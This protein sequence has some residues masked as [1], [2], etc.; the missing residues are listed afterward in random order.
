MILRVAFQPRE[1]T[2]P[3]RKLCVVIDVLRAT[4]TLAT[5]LQAGC[6]DILLEPT[7][8]A[9]RASAGGRLLCGEEG[10]VRPEGFDFGNSPAEFART[11]L[12]GKAVT[13]ATTNGTK[14]LQVARLSPLV[15]AG[16]ALNGPAVTTL[17]LREAGARGLDVELICAGRIAGTGFSL[18]DAVCA[19]YLV[20]L[21]VRH[22]GFAPR[23]SGAQRLGGD[24]GVEPVQPV[25]GRHLHDSALAAWRLFRS[26]TVAH[27]DPGIALLAAFD[28]SA[29]GHGLRALAL[30]DDVEFCARAGLVAVV[31]QAVLDGERVRVVEARL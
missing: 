8:A 27:R 29:S 31:P 13:F 21:L 28:E 26:Y 17:A 6:R 7:V 4:S 14:A 25:E 16:S 11:D 18:D 1:V 5:M 23:P 2:D 9:A 15:Y 19:G 24:A 12:R 3:E 20:D 22:G 10:G 30:G